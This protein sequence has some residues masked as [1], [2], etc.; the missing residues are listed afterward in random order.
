MPLRVESA[1]SFNASI[2]PQSIAK[3]PT[4]ENS[5]VIL[6]T[7]L[8]RSAQH[9]YRVGELKPDTSEKDTLW[10]V[11][12]NALCR[13]IHI[14]IT[15]INRETECYWNWCGEEL[16][17]LPVRGVLKM[18]I[19]YIPVL[20][21]L[22]RRDGRAAFVEYGSQDTWSNNFSVTPLPVWIFWKQKAFLYQ[23]NVCPLANLPC[24]ETVRTTHL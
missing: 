23:W 10:S 20:E 19:F 13:S 6:L 2:S 9:H 7:S 18:P 24:I 22:T 4:L 5:T 11:H 8:I 17:E 3:Y 14:N 12:R 15:H 21:M 16:S 1:A